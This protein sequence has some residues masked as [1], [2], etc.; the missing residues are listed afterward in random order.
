MV[1]AGNQEVVA[2]IAGEPVA[3]EAAGRAGIAGGNGG[4]QSDLTMAVEPVVAG[5]AEDDV[6]AVAAFD[7]VVAV[8]AVQVV[9]TVAAFDPVVAVAAADI[10]VEFAGENVVVAGAAAQDVFVGAGLADGVALGVA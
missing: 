9:L 7:E 1:G 6:A 8:F 3:L 2:G 4:L 10:V 5:F